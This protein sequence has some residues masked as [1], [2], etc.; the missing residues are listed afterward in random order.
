M[1][2]QTTHAENT[3]EYVINTWQDLCNIDV[4]HTLTTTTNE[5]PEGLV[6]S[7]T[8][9]TDA[10]TMHHTIEDGIERT[11]CLPKN[12]RFQTPILMQ[13]GMWH[14]AWCWQRWQELFAQWGW[15]SHAFSL[16]GHAGSPTQR[17]I[18]Y[19]TLDY[20]LYFLKAEVDR[21]PC[22]PVLIG[23][24]MGGAITQWYLKY[25][26]KL[27]AVVF[28]G[29]WVSHHA[30]RDWMFRVL[31]LDPRGCMLTLKEGTATAMIR[32][33]QRA[34]RMFITEGAIY[35][36]EELHAKLGPE[37]SLVMSQ[38]QPPIW[39][40]PKDLELPMLWLDG[41]KDVLLSR[42]GA[43]RSASFY[44]AKYVMVRG[45][46]HDLMLERSYRRTAETIH[47]WLTEQELAAGP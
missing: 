40:P 28:V 34:A 26:G 27:P 47:D 44:G 1:T 10:Y 2:N 18:R 22:P 15:K 32:T 11:T 45:A 16:P 35:S 33:P 21:L 14:G 6:F 23:H 19:C 46:G 17:P 42:R 9:E 5:A 38:H 30:F 7:E 13:H 29:S 41:E 39:S 3:P 43:R 25:V 37:S 20:Y 24:S 31:W 12:E 36:P 4:Q 8:K